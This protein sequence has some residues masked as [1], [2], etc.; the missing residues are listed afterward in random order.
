MCTDN[1]SFP[2]LKIRLVLLK[3]RNQENILL[4]K[5]LEM[6]WS[7]HFILST[8]ETQ[9]ICRHTAH[10]YHSQDFDFLSDALILPLMKTE[11]LQL[12]WFEEKGI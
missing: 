3:T 6:I 4:E 12:N 11:T 5:V 1:E 2:T 8:I 7:K 10:C 9:T